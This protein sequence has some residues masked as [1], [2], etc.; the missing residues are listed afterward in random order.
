MSWQK[1]R[2]SLSFGGAMLVRARL[3]RTARQMVPGIN[4][5]FNTTNDPAAGLFTTA[6]FPGASAANL[7][8]ARDLYALLT[9]R[10]IGR[11]R[12][13]GARPG[14]RTSTSRSAPGRR[15]GRIGHALALRPGLVAA[16]PG[17]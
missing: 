12:A 13:G 8:D 14:E 4:L 17:P 2:H 11:H 7:A 10:V 5:G 16:S 3:R 9:G 15:E 1:G 6:N